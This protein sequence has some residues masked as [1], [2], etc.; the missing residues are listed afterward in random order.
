MNDM[1]YTIYIDTSTIYHP[2]GVLYLRAYARVVDNITKTPFGTH[3][4]SLT[5]LLTTQYLIFGDSRGVPK[6]GYPKIYRLN[7]ESLKSENTIFI[8]TFM[9]SDN[10]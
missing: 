5:L 2:A 7:S 3:C 10:I 8:R 9:L 1:C 6:Y 4:I